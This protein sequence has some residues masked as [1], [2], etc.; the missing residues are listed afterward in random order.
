MEPLV[1]WLNWL[2]IYLPVYFVLNIIIPL[3][4][5]RK[6]YLMKSVQSEKEK[7][8]YEK[9]KNHTMTLAG[10]I[11]AAL[12]III[13]LPQYTDDK[14]SHLATFYFSISLTCFF[15]GSYLFDYRIRRIFPFLGQVAEYTG[16]LSLGLGFLSFANTIFKDDLFI[17]SIYGIFMVAISAITIIEIYYNK[18][19][20]EPSST[21]S[22][23][24]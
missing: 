12:A 8:E 14:V 7:Q 9:L 2:W 17:L 24:K 15:V 4:Y 3:A 6:D 21:V 20:F 16:V 13:A 1:A 19:F 22:E 10:F 23:T 5:K 18:K 11:M